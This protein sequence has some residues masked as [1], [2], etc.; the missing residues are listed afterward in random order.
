LSREE[1]AK[2]LVRP[3]SVE[4]ALKCYAEGSGGK[5]LLLSMRDNPEENVAFEVVKEKE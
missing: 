2:L 3:C 1:L 4:E 5:V